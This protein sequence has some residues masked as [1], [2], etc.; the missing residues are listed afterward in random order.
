VKLFDVR[1]AD[2]QVVNHPDGQIALEFAKGVS[3]D[4]QLDGS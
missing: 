2:A 1:V 3:G 4:A